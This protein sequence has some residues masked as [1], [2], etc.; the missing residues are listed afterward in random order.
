M[1]RH[2]LLAFLLLALA[3]CGQD[4]GKAERTYVKNYFVTGT[5]RYGVD[6]GGEY[7]GSSSQYES[8][9][10]GYSTSEIS[11]DY[12]G[13]REVRTREDGRQINIERFPTGQ[14]KGESVW[15]Y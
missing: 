5:T 12:T 10:G 3:G 15:A 13:S 6:E 2:A 1:G 11:G 4:S 9:H 7:S 8:D 14:R